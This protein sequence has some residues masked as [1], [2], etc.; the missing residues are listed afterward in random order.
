MLRLEEERGEHEPFLARLFVACSTLPERLPPALIEHQALAQQAGHRREF[1]HAMRRV[2]FDAD[3]PI[4]RIVVDWSSPE[5]SRGVDIAVLPTHRAS[6]AG[7][8]L[9]RAWLAVADRQ[10]RRCHLSVLR[11][12]PAARL[13]RR[14]GFAP[15]DDDGYSP[16]VAMT[17]APRPPH[18]TA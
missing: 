15:V 18:V 16:V 12:N 3:R 6:G 4:A 13:Y 1:P 8:A 17:R 5:L 7:A 11:D 10:R 9:L 2:V 14:L